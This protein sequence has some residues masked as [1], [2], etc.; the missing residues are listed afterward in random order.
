MISILVVFHCSMKSWRLKVCLKVSKNGWRCMPREKVLHFEYQTF[1]FNFCIH[2]TMYCW[3]FGY[4][5]SIWVENLLFEINN[6]QIALNFHVWKA[7][8][9]PFVS[10]K[11][12]KVLEFFNHVTIFS[13]FM[14][15]F[16]TMNASTLSTTNIDNSAL[17]F[18]ETFFLGK[19]C[20][21][22]FLTRTKKLMK[23]VYYVYRMKISFIHEFLI[24]IIFHRIFKLHR[25]ILHPL[26]LSRR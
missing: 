9:L 7:L 1:W 20:S 2:F 23:Y 4:T 6:A 15:F 11:L 3:R 25:I 24:F 16:S 19:V 22:T 17:K 18:H 26:S 8:N 10:G 21:Q 12:S 5:C 13:I 14:R